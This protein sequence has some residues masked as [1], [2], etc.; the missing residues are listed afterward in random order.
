VNDPRTL[1][2]GAGYDAMIDTWES[3]SARIEDDPRH[4]WAA[5]LAERLPEHAR[6]LELGCGGGT[7]ETAFL[8]S[9]FELT[10]VDLSTRQLERARERVPAATFVHGDLTSLEHE[11][12]AFDA[13]VSFYVFNHVPRELLAPLLGR[14]RMWLRE[15]GLLLA[16]FGTADEES[17]T[18]D[19]LGAPTF[20]SSFPPAVNSALVRDAGFAIERDEVVSIAEPEGPVAFQWILAARA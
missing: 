19:F 2:V 13:V 10:G 17:W 4:A 9:R 15:P 16:A 14:I 6:V 8:A 12:G 5:L 20:F 3:W 18:G 1:L 11:P 7:R